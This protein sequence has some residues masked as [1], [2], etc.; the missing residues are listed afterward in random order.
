MKVD[1]Y[2][3]ISYS[4]ITDL[5][6]NILADYSE[7][8]FFEKEDDNEEGEDDLVNVSPGAVLINEIMAD[9][10]GLTDLPETVYVELYNTTESSITLSDWQ[11][12]YG[13]KAKPMITFELP[14]ESYAVLYRSGR[15]I[16]VDPSAVQ[17]P[18]YGK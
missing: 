14:A 17:I 13:G 6:D 16:Q 8:L 3:T 12:S 10:K 7:E 2:Y 9:P 15:D 18:V 11:F 5:S 4:G 1:N